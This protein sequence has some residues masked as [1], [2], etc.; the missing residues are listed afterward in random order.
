MYTHGF[1]EVEI[2]VR[3]AGMVASFHSVGRVM[4]TS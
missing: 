4:D 2:P 3:V 1:A